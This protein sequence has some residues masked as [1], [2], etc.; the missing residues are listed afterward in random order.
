MPCSWTPRH[1]ARGSNQ[2]PCGYQPT[3]STTRATVNLQTICVFPIHT[4]LWLFQVDSIKLWV[5]SCM[6]VYSIN[7]W[8]GILLNTHLLRMT[9][10]CSKTLPGHFRKLS[11]IS[12][13]CYGRVP[14]IGLKPG[15]SYKSKEEFCSLPIPQTV[16]RCSCGFARRKRGMVHYIIWVI[17]LRRVWLQAIGLRLQ[18]KARQGVLYIYKKMQYSHM[19]RAY[20]FIIKWMY[21]QCLGR[22]AMQHRGL[23]A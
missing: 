5:Y 16:C 4:A 7:T 3:R 22:F 9:R 6:R 1:S 15:P 12:E 11:L 21:V 23:Y 14:A 10:M 20:T 17:I 2:K 18:G 8:K 19:V 13:R